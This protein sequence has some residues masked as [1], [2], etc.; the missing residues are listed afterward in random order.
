[1]AGDLPGNIPRGLRTAIES[2]TASPLT[3]LGFDPNL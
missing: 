1:M 2:P 3:E